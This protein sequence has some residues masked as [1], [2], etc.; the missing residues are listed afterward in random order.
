MFKRQNYNHLRRWAGRMTCFGLTLSLSLMLQAQT[1]PG[2]RG[3]A[4]GAGGPLSGLGNKES[5]N[6]S[7]GLDA[8]QEVA[9]VTGSINGTEGGLGPR[10]NLNSCSGCHIHPAVGGSSPPIIL[11]LQ[12]QS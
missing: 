1:D 10:F 2:P 11:S 7:R 12:W 5:Q 4:P 6:F 8:F 3:G 9:S